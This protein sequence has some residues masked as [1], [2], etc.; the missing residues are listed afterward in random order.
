[1]EDTA[2]SAARDGRFADFVRLFESDIQLQSN[3]AL[4]YYILWYVIEQGYLDIV[5]Y[6]CERPNAVI[7]SSPRS[8]RTDMFCRVITAGHLDVFKYLVETQ[9]F[10]PFDIQ[11]HTG[12]PLHNAARLGRLDFIAY[13][14]ET[15]GVCVDIL[16]AEL[17]TPLHDA[18][19][20]R[21]LEA[22]R[23]LIARGA[24]V[25]AQA[26]TG[27]TPLH[28]AADG[29][30]EIVKLLIKSGADVNATQSNMYPARTPLYMA[31]RESV[32]YENVLYIWRHGGKMRDPP[33]HVL[34]LDR[35]VYIVWALKRGKHIPYELGARVSDA[36]FSLKTRIHN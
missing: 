6:M 10:D 15:L 12:T 20:H 7:I 14:I 34:N 33:R 18:V 3:Y 9:K 22:A 36:L 31:S 4:C 30:L 13:M 1:M 23:Y 17:C 29:L 5:T 24:N 11:E 25:N 26:R 28:A 19:S 2:V 8:I 32:N 21:K 27:F 35:T 16:D